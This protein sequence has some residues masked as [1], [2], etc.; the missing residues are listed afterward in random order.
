MLIFE[1]K[2]KKNNDEIKDE[3]TKPL[4]DTDQ[5]LNEADETRPL[6]NVIDA[7]LELPDEE[8]REVSERSLRLRYYLKMPMVMLIALAGSVSSCSAL[9]LKVSDTI[10]QK[11][12]GEGYYFW[13]IMIGCLSIATGD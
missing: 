13:L 4:I 2:K 3:E 10:L 7:L 6:R 1:P 5:I 11:G 12:D 9:L 8:I